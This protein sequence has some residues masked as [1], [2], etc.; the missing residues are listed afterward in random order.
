MTSEMRV[1]D[2]ARGFSVIELLFA[3]GLVATLSGVA[4][5]LLLR[6][7]DDY[8]AAGAARYIASRLQRARMEAV[9]RSTNV[10]VRFSTSGEFATYVDGNDNGVLSADIRDGSDPRLGAAERISSS[11]SGVEFGVLAGLPPVESGAAPPGSDPIH[12]GA[13]DAASFTPLGTSSSGSIY[14]RSGSR[15]V[16]VRIYGDTGKVRILRF[17]EGPRQWRGL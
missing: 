8:R 17:D 3:A 4:M 14:L 6:T 2:G 9:L 1:P 5:P 13:S 12:L 7:L 10:A 15:Q 16:V 11:I